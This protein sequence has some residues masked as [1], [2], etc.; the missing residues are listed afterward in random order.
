MKE[1]NE[2]APQFEELPTWWL[3]FVPLEKLMCWKE[4]RNKKEKGQ[5]EMGKGVAEKK[6]KHET[7]TRYSKA[8]NV[9]KTTC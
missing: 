4:T 7:G 5:K 8:K 9:L 3:P 1:K 2:A 6:K